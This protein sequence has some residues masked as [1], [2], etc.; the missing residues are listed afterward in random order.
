M[1]SHHT[2]QGDK[3]HNEDVSYS[4]HFPAT[5]KTPE[6][7]VLGCF[8]G[9]GVNGEGYQCASY[10]ASEVEKWMQWLLNKWFSNGVS[11]EE[12][13]KINWEK[14]A[15]GMTHRI[16]D[17]YRK[18]CA[19]KKGRKIVE[20]VVL[21]SLEESLS[22]YQEAVHSGSTFSLAIV[23]HLGSSYK[24]ILIQVGDSDIAVNGEMVECNHTPLSVE[25]WKR[26]QDFPVESR[27][28]FTYYKS[29]PIFLPNGEYDPTYYKDGKWSWDKG[30]VPSCAKYEPSTR[31]ISPP[32]YPYPVNIGMTRAI[33]N[34]YVKG[35]M[36][37]TPKVTVIHTETRPFVLIMTDGGWDT[38]NTKN[39]WEYKKNRICGIQKSD[40]EGI[41]VKERV[42]VLHDLYHKL[43]GQNKADD[44]SIAMFM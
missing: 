19:S 29:D 5:N 35:G 9:H 24:T 27:V 16:H 17:G 44:I 40:W 21:Y 7:F 25:E 26:I 8:D 1:L 18:K 30:L 13:N 41:T 3:E 22:F 6:C 33:G 32:D 38:I 42:N 20:D 14:L 28:C 43:F 39:E 4:K 31:I 37:P 12:I 34:F 10:C 11:I 23:I 2:R 36:I 15:T